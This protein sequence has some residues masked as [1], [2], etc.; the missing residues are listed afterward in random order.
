MTLA[1]RQR[2]QVRTPVLFLSAAAWILLMAA[3]GSL[4]LSGHCTVTGL[5]AML[6]LKSLRHLMALNPPGSV[7]VGWTLMLIAMMAPVVIP[8]VR[9]IRDR[10]F[11]RRRVRAIIL[12]VGGYAAIWMA[13][14][15]LLLAI[16]LVVR[17]AAPESLLP[18]ALVAIVA[19]VWQFSPV[20]QQCLNRCHAHP[21][22]AA[23]SPAADL[24][25]LR[26]GLTHGI[27]CVGSCWALMLLPLLV[28]RG[29]LAVMVL[30]SLCL[31]AERLDRPVP[32]RWSWR[33]PSKAIRIAIAQAR[34]RLARG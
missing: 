5:G 26:F 14:G 17:L 33:A 34:M 10:S 3:P 31:F 30:V 4:G 16:V 8:P 22:V 7:A 1:S 25:A 24:G 13:A 20:K 18:V 32:P 2:A 9:H 23:F 11:A 28:S 21:E 19:L 15:V 12:F 27:W 6:S 29:H